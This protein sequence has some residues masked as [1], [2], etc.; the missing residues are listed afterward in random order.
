M[1]RYR[2]RALDAQGNLHKGIETAANPQALRQALRRRGLVPRRVTRSVG[3][4]RNRAPWLRTAELTLA[5]RQ[6]A[7]LLQAA[8]PLA[9]ALEAVIRQMHANPAAARVIQSVHTGVLEGRSLAAAMADQPR[10]FSSLYRATVEAGEQSGYLGKVL[11]QL[12][13]HLE[14]RQLA[15]QRIRTALVY[16]TLLLVVSTVIVG[17]L[18][19]Y[20]IPDILALFTGSGQALPWPTRLLLNLTNGLG[21]VWPY[22]VVTLV[23]SA[24]GSSV[25]LRKPTVRTWLDA[26]WLRLP[27]LGSTL[28]NAEAARYISTLAIMLGSGVTLLPALRIANAVVTN[29]ALRGRLAG[30]APQVAEGGSLASA[31]DATDAISPLMLQLIASGEQSGD[32]AGLMQRAADQQE[33]L[34]ANRIALVLSL[35][36]PLMLVGMGLVVM[37]IVMGVLLPI[38]SLN[39]LVT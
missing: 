5:T 24:L 36:E 20:V 7:T 16:P 34:L 11:E 39:Q 37:F 31:L 28:R 6:L 13:D 1:N 21:L 15:Q 8:V 17:F 19:G 26:Q 4:L 29:L 25:A 27:L 32:L 38:L 12:A 2:F 22:L 14:A 3:G 23:L 33:K 10:I 9:N 18:L 30:V 35:F